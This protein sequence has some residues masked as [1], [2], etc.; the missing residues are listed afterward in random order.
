MRCRSDAL[1]RW[2]SLDT[3]LGRAALPRRLGPFSAQTPADRQV[4]PTGQC[5][6]PS[7]QE[8][9]KDAPDSIFGNFHSWLWQFLG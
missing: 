5:F 4:S 2:V 9:S 6:A 3:V 8:Q 7:S 1:I